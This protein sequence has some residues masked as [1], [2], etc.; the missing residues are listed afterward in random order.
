MLLG[1]LSGLPD[2]GRLALAAVAVAAYVP[3]AGAGPSIQRA[4]V[5]GLAALAALA[6]A[7]STA[8]S[9][10]SGSPPPSP[11]ALDPRAWM[12]VGWQLSFAATA[13]LLLA[14]GPGQRRLRRL[15]IPRL[16]ATPLATTAAATLA[17]APVMLATFGTVSAIGLVTNLAAAPAAAVAVWSGVLAALTR[18]G[19]RNSRA[20]SPN[21]CRR[22]S[23]TLALAG[24]G[25]G[26]PHAE[27]GAAALGVALLGGVLLVL[28]R[29][30]TQLSLAAGLGL[31]SWLALSTHRP[32]SQPRL[33]V[34]DIGRAA[35]RCCRMARGRARRCRPRRW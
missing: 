7:A 34:L 3:L 25:A 17:T 9:T 23:A 32:P 2:R 12:D 30:G 10:H 29:P 11:L 27:I 18:P 14:V 24:W 20:W 5:M 28:L 31:L 13:G 35:R 19:P 21:Q 15:G 8:R 4:G 26:R 1:W 33:V 16:L 22:A 6:A